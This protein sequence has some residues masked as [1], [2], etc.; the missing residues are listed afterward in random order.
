MSF[1]AYLAR[2][3]GEYSVDTVDMIDGAWRE[4]DFGSYDAVFHVAGIVHKKET[5][6]NAELYYKVNRDLVIETA[7]KAKDEGV[8]HFVFLSTVSVYGMD[9]GIITKDTVPVPKSNYG[10]SK[11]QAEE[12]LE[13]MAADTFTVTRIRP[14]MVYGE[15]CKGNY[16]TLVKIAQKMPFF[17]N[18][19]N[20]RSL[21]HIDNLTA[22]VK[23]V[24]DDKRGGVF[25]PQD[26][27]YS[28]TCR[29]IKDIA[30]DMG[31]DIKL[32]N[33]LNP[34]VA[35]FRVCTKKGKKAFGNLIYKE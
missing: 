30:A 9:E 21:I 28:C 1:E 27:E 33:V 19:E 3:G 18:Y 31:K 13:K 7:Q 2:F 35:L 17:A 34:L 24:I 11:L 25:F 10:K 8:P 22:F 4:K 29:M 5:K 14:P 6:E 26:A 32:L 16:Q 20:E 12:A 15:G 23:G